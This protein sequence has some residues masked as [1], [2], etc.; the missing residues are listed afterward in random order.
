M[1]LQL[2]DVVETLVVNNEITD[3]EIIETI[4]FLIQDNICRSPKTFKK[5]VKIINEE[6][7]FET[8]EYD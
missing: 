3:K 8:G 7:E 6:M 1:K 5:I 4:K 2:H